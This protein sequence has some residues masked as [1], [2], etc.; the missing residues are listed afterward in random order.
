MWYTPPA[1]VV[2]SLTVNLWVYIYYSPIKLL[3]LH[4]KWFNES[5]WR[6]CAA[7]WGAGVLR[8]W[9]PILIRQNRLPSVLA[10]SNGHPVPREAPGGVEVHRC[11]PPGGGPRKWPK[12]RHL[13]LYK[14]AGFCDSAKIAWGRFFCQIGPKTTPSRPPPATPKLPIPVRLTPVTG[15]SCVP[16]DRIG[17]LNV[18]KNVDT[19]YP[20][21]SSCV[22]C[23]P[24]SDN[25]DYPKRESLRFGSRIGTTIHKFT[26]YNPLTLAGGVYYIIFIYIYIYYYLSECRQPRCRTPFG[27]CTGELKEFY[28]KRYI[29]VL[30]NIL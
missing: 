13:V 29:I 7:S 16:S 3:M 10:N 20:V 28:K 15:R 19:T 26:V 2:G 8:V 9:E 30:R 1:S 24:F 6:T 17:S 27:F 23:Q 21:P 22:N 4:S 14:L 18:W 25:G 5:C 12:K 11:D